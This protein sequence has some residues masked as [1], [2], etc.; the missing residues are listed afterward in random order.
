MKKILLISVSFFL[1]PFF[2]FSK[3][4]YE[5]ASSAGTMMLDSII[6]CE[7]EGTI[8]PHNGD[9]TLDSGDIIRAVIHD[10]NGTILGNVFG[11]QMPINNFF[12]VPP[13]GIIFGT[14]YYISAIAGMDDGTG[15]V[16]LND[17]ELSVAQGTPVI[18]GESIETYLS[19]TICEGSFIIVG[20]DILTT[21]GS[22]II[23]E[24][25]VLGCDSV[26]FVDLTVLDPQAAIFPVT[27]MIDCS[28]SSV[29]INAVVLNPS[30]TVTYKWTGPCF[31]QGLPQ[32]SSIEV[33]CAGTYTLEVCETQNGMTCV[34]ETVSVEVFE[35]TTPPVVDAGPDLEINCAITSVT[36]IP[37][38]SPASSTYA[39]AWTGANGYSA[40]TLL[41]VFTEPGEYCFFVVDLN[42]SCVSNT[43]CMIVTGDNSAPVAVASVSNNLDCNNTTAVLSAFNSSTGSNIIYEWIDSNG[44][45]I[46][47]GMNILVA[48]PGI[49]TLF[50]TDITNGCFTSTTINV[51]ENINT[52]VA[53]ITSSGNIDCNNSSVTL[54]GSSSTGNALNYL[55]STGENTVSIVASWAG[56]YTLYVTDITNGCTSETS[57]FVDDTNT[58]Q[59]D[60]GE[61]T[62]FPCD[63]SEMTISGNSIP[64]GTGFSYLWTTVDGSIIS[65]EN[66]ID[67]I[68][69]LPGTYVLTVD[70][71]I[72][73]CTGTDEIVIYDFD[74]LLSVTENL[75][76]D[77]N[78]AIPNELE[79]SLLLPN[80]DITYSWTTSNGN[81]TSAT[82]IIN[83]TV[84]AAGV[85]VLEVT[86]N[87]TGCIASGNV[88]M[89]NPMLPTV[90]IEAQGN[91]VLS[92]DNSEVILDGANSI[93]SPP[94]LFEW[95]MNSSIISSN[96]LVTVTEGGVYDLE[97]TDLNGCSSTASYIVTVDDNPP[98]YTLPSEVMLN[99]NNNFIEEVGPVIDSA[100]PNVTY[101]WIYNGVIYSSDS[102][103]ILTENTQGVMELV[104]TDLDNGCSLAS[105]VEI[106]YDG[107]AIDVATT[108]AGCD[109][110]DGT[111]TAST[112]LANTLVEW[113][114][115]EQGNTIS[116]LA[117]GWYS[118]TV[119]DTD[120][121][122]NRH[123]NF[124]V[125]EDISCKVVI[126]GY[127]LLDPNNTCTYDVSLEGVECVMVKL[128]PLGIYT[129]TDATGY[130]EFIVDDGSYTVEYTGS[131]A[132]DLQCPIPATYD[133]TLSTNGSISADNHFYVLR[134][135]FDLCITK[136]I[137]AA[138][139]GFNQF[140]CVQ[141]CNYGDEVADA[142]VTFV[143]DSIFAQV[144]PLPNIS[145]INSNATNYT[146]D[147]SAYTF[148]WN[149]TD[150]TPGECQKIMWYMEV[151]QTAM[152]GDN[153][154]A[155]AKVNPIVDDSDPSNNCLAWNLDITGS[156]DPNDKR[157]FVGA[158]QW[159]GAIFESDTTMEY[160]IRFQNVGNDTAFTVVVRDTLDEEHLDV[161]TIRGFTASHDMQ[162]Q[163]EDSNVLIFTFENIMLVDS[164]TNEPGSNGW[165]NFDIDRKPNQPFGTE[166]TNQA[167]IYFDF[168]APVITNELVNFLTN[169]VNVFSP[170]KNT[171]H[172]EITPTI[173]NDEI[174]VNYVLEN[175][176]S[177][178]M[179]IY[180]VGGVLLQNIDF[181]K[182]V[183]GE[184]VEH[185][186]LK[187]FTAGVYFVFV[188][189]EEGS[190]VRKVVKM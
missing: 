63:V 74:D 23:T 3:N 141:I 52:P 67:P 123:E 189:T 175:T 93:V 174:Q 12:N 106:S 154:S 168:N 92:C 183:T 9:E 178:S 134:P 95:R 22:F 6:L 19:E 161:T 54:D 58:Y 94:A 129:M 28:G 130:Y 136:N 21:S 44:N 46:G 72:N 70:D 137:G 1:I 126:G 31:T 89:D 96:V 118:V 8:I 119:T 103:I 139:P 11:S 57:I 84:N 164:A 78:P 173:T 113:S 158:S 87:L 60:L 99:C 17:P 85:Y 33:S 152:I 29:Q 142:V 132:V 120:N 124:F 138:R 145:P 49:F 187:D 149:L 79:A 150:L 190:A 125:D 114:T 165:L 13:P 48:S 102:S 53:I 153:I 105:I 109:L 166:I 71:A 181:G 14:T 98:S 151:P 81:F 90:I 172:V 128:D 2:L 32:A 66:T 65:G 18:F 35:N 176:N 143:H 47:G 112:T 156:Y 26:I 56:T 170:I 140:N 16:D 133:V 117:Q 131:A 104:V 20:C 45:S 43:D 179:Q 121:N 177:V 75:I 107:F 51:S 61:D 69:N 116:N 182:K 115:G 80:L 82:D 25:S 167:A 169:P 59:I 38:V 97:V 62:F 180:N 185:L 7:G 162:V 111:A 41:P 108:P 34:S 148:T 171:L 122:C 147:E 110:E 40:S 188:K 159:G 37:T 30:P 5:I 160:A 184:Y 163:F 24:V 68:I 144:T 86:D 146:Y 4:N 83:P 157:N 50:V 10:N 27:N 155:E 88:M 100:N 42:T 77:C 186:S 55:W 15:N 91:S 127:V 76:L 36:G 135:N 73:G 39:Y 101:E 64:T